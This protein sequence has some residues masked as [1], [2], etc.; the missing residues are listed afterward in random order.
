MLT[1]DQNGYI[2]NTDTAYEPMSI[3]AKAFGAGYWRAVA[4]GDALTVKGL[5]SRLRV[6]VAKAA[7]VL[8][9]ARDGYDSYKVG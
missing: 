7:L 3:E 4:G 9:I 5:A 6:S 8:A 1:T 2:I